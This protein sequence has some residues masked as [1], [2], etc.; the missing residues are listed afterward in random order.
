MSIDPNDDRF[1]LF[2]VDIDT[3]PRNTLAP[4]DAIINPLTWAP[5]P[6]DSSYE[7]VRYL[8]TEPTGNPDNE[9][10]AVAWQGANGRALVAGANDIVE[11]SDNYWHVVFSSA[12]TTD[13]QYVTNMTT[14]IQYEWAGAQWIKSYQ[15]SYPGGTWRLVL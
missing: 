4:I 7:G 3:I 1:L 11:Y 14:G 9:Y 12:N 13:I 2:D 10:P 15:G 5:D 6:A 8:L